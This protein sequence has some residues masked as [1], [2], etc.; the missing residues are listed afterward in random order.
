MKEKK[1]NEFPE[2]SKGVKKLD[3]K[4]IMKPRKEKTQENVCNN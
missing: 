2:E 4:I 3:K 1:Q